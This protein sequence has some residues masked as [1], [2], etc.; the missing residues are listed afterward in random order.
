LWRKFKDDLLKE[1]DN[2][3]RMDRHP[4]FDLDAFRLRVPREQFRHH[5]LV[6]GLKMRQQNECQP[7][8]GGQAGE[9]LFECL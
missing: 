1:V 7:G 2:V 5:A 6:C 9:E 4:V 8:I 3:V